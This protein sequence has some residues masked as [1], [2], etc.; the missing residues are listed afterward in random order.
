MKIA[1]WSGQLQVFILT[2]TVRGISVQK[3]R[4]YRLQGNQMSPQ[5]LLYL[6]QLSRVLLATELGW[7]NKDNQLPLRSLIYLV[8]RGSKGILA[9]SL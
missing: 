2:D 5:K 3:W 7:K 6:L 4:I 9:V 1:C 8:R